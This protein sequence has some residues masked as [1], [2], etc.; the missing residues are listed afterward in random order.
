MKKLLAIILIFLP[1]ITL[2]EAC[3]PARRGGLGTCTQPTFGQIPYGN[4]LQSY[5]PVNFSDIVAPYISAINF[6]SDNGTVLTPATTTRGL[7]INGATTLATTTIS[8]LT[9]SGNATTSGYSTLATT[10]FRFDGN[11]SSIFGHSFSAG[12]FPYDYL[13]MTAG[14]LST[15]FGF[16]NGAYIWKTDNTNV[17]PYI[18]FGADNTAN[19]LYLTFATSTNQFIVGTVDNN[20]NN[21]DIGKTIFRSAIVDILAGDS[22][23][24]LYFEAN[25]NGVFYGDG[26]LKYATTTDVLSFN[27][28][29]GGYTFDNRVGIGTTT[30]NASLSLWGSFG[31]KYEKKSTDYYVLS[32][33]NTIIASSTSEIDI[34][35]PDPIENDG[36]EFKI[37]DDQTSEVNIGC[38]TG[39]LVNQSATSTL[40]SKRDM[41]TLKAMFGEYYIGN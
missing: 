38:V 36:K 19:I 31:T 15:I 9:I 39:C 41:V 3:Y 2:S 20:S 26:H 6:W 21:V 27:D 18:Y 13:G 24:S 40:S 1:L 11:E 32:T 14:V 4:S 12:T 8:N 37:Y 25:K 33:D 17:P 29:S 28:F 5:T 34:Y 22:D 10:T 7:T 23:P 30:P 16:D 35:L